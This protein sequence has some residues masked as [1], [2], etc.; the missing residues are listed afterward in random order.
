MTPAPSPR[1]RISRYRRL[2]W[3][4]SLLACGLSLLGLALCWLNPS[5]GAPLR[6][7]LD[8]TGG[9]QVQVGRDCAPCNAIT[10]ADFIQGNGWLKDW[11]SWGGSELYAKIEK[12]PEKYL[13]K[14]GLLSPLLV[15][16]NTNEVLGGNGRL[17]AIKELGWDEVW[18][19]YVE[20]KDENERIELALLD[21]NQFGNYLQEK[22]EE[23]I[24]DVD[25]ELWIKEN[26]LLGD[27]IIQAIPEGVGI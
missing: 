26:Q 16:K 7:G 22:L 12:N 2:A 18:I 25:I 13:E 10:A 6:P 15:D 20:P 27:D 3:V 9:T 23:L 24:A 1:F 14:Y 19:K 17:K 4:G 5:I 21:N 11:P 8:F